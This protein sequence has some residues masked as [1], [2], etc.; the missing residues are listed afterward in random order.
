MT[1]RLRKPYVTP[2]SGDESDDNNLPLDEQEQEELI[3]ELQKE[4]DRKNAF[5]IVCCPIPDAY[6]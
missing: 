6:L 5:F 2:S 1:S 4:N 3:E